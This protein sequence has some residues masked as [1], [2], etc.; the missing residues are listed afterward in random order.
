MVLADSDALPRKDTGATLAHQDVAGACHLTVI[1][2]H[3]EIFRVGICQIFGG[4]ACF[5]MGHICWLLVTR[6]WLC[7]KVSMSIKEKL[8]KIKGWQE[9]WWSPEKLLERNSFVGLVVFLVALSS[10]ALGRLSAIEANKSPVR[11]LFPK[12]GDENITASAVLFENS[13]KEEILPPQPLPVANTNT[14]GAYVASKSGTK[15]HLPW[16]SGA[17]RIKEENKIW[18]ASKEEAEA[19]GYTPAANCKGI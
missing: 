4:T 3:P 12:D 10:F 18:F 11:I 2:F 19:K 9:K 8:K 5:F 17:K 7:Y 1:N 6:N 13:K 16:C 14:Q 15:Y